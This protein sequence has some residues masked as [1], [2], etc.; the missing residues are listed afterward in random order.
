MKATHLPVLLLLVLLAG[1]AGTPATT[2]TPTNSPLP[3]RPS[4]LVLD[5]VDPCT[6]ITPTQRTQLLVGKPKSVRTK[7][8][9][10]LAACLWARFPQEP[11]DFYLISMDVKL[12]AEYA[13]ASDSGSRVI[14]ING[15]TAV[16]S[17]RSDTPPGVNCMLAVDVAAGQNLAIRYDYFGSTVP[18]TTQSSC[19]KAA[20]LARMAVQTM[21]EQNIR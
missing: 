5:R 17:Q 2:A 20:T 21:L 15:F 12:G 10:D 14:D 1:C 19:E 7:D 3:A 16:E 13:L 8:G 9:S 4:E 6:I 11:Q 18:M